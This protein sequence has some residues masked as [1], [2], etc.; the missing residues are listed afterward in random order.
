[1]KTYLTETLSGLLAG[2]RIEANTFKEAESKCPKGYRV[3]GE[4]IDE[5]DAPEFDNLNLN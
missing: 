3:I 4:L 5:I 1:M 2:K